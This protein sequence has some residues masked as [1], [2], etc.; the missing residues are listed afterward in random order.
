M[1]G[2]R[3]FFEEVEKRLA[4]N[5]LDYLPALEPLELK[6]LQTR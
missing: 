1:Y 5:L 4:R 2:Q 6:H 3:S